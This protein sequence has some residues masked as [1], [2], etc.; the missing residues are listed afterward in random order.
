MCIFHTLVTDGVYIQQKDQ[1]YQFLRLPH[2]THEEL[3][4]L[5]IKIERIIIK[6]NLEQTDQ[7]PLEEELLGDIAQ[8]SIT[9][10][11]A[12]GER[13]GQRLR[14][15]GIKSLEVDPENHDPTAANNSGYSLNARVWIAYN[16]K[17]T[18]AGDTAIRAFIL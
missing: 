8:M 5:V 18:R 6:L 1:A 9:K 12:F 4:R 10:R 13:Q 2:P 7:M 16:K 3:Q 14:Q 17:K 11:A 15:Y